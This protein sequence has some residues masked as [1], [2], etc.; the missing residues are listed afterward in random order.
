MIAGAR[1][2]RPKDISDALWMLEERCWAQEPA[3]RPGFEVVE[4]EIGTMIFG[5][6][7]ERKGSALTCT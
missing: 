3:G 5:R 6:G 1:P 7:A 2:E 4:K